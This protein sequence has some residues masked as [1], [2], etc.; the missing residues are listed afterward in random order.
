MRRL[1]ALALAVVLPALLPARA[2]DADWEVF[3]QDFVEASGRVVDNG[4]GGISHSEGQGYAML[5]AVHYGD[6]ATFEDPMQYPVG[7]RHVVVGGE[8]VV[9]DGELTGARPGKVVN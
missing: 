9:R 5:F 6:R 2:A 3:R 8:V 1:A 7:I 4:Q